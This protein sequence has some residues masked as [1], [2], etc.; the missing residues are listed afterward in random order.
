M[1][2]HIFKQIIG[3]SLLLVMLM[4][5]STY[6]NEIDTTETYQLMYET[7]SLAEAEEIASIFDLDLV[8]FSDFGFSVYEADDIHKKDDYLKMGF[9]INHTHQIVR[10]NTTPDSN[11]D[12]YLDN[13]YAIPMMGVD[14]AWSLELGDPNYLIAIIDTGID[15]DHEEF[16]NRIS[17]L[18]YNAITEEVGIDAVEDENGHGTN[19]AGIIGAT[20]NNQIGIAGIVQNSMLLI[21]KAN[22]TDDPSTTDEDESEVF[23]DSNI[24]K[25]INYAVENG[26]DV[27]NLSLGG[28]GFNSIVQNAINNA[29]DSGSIVVASSGN[30]GT[31]EL[32]Y[33][34]SYNHVISVGAVD[35]NM[36]IASY[37][38]YNDEVDISAPGTAIATTNMNDTYVTASGTSFAAPQVTAIIALFQ[39]YL[40]HYTDAQTIERLY[41]TAMDRG[42]VGKDDFYGHGIINAYQSMLV[43]A[44][45]VSFDTDGGTIIDPIRI[46]KDETF[47]VDDPTKVGYD[48]VGW[49]LDENLTQAFNIGTDTRNL[50]TTLYAKYA[51]KQFIISFVTS[52]TEVSPI[53]VY[54]GNP[55]IEPETSKEGFTFDGWYYDSG[56]TSKYDGQLITGQTTFYAKFIKDPYI[57]NFYVEGI[58]NET[59]EINEGET[60]ELYTP[61]GDGNFLGWYLEP[62]LD[63]L[64]VSSGVTT[65]LNLYAK[66]DNDQYAVVYYESDLETIKEIQYISHGQS[67][68]EPEAPMKTSTASFEYIFLNWS[69]D[70]V[71]ITESL[72]IY[73]IFERQFIEGSV[74]LNAGLD[75]VYQKDVW[76]NAGLN[77]D[78]DLLTYVLRNEPDLEMVGR[79]VL[80]YDLYANDEVV[81]TLVRVVNVIAQPN[82]KISLN[83]DITTIF[84][85]DTYEDAGATSTFGEV[86][87]TNDVDTTTSGVYTVTYQVFY[88][89]QYYTKIKYVYV[90]EPLDIS[91]TQS[92]DI[93]EKQK[94]WLS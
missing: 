20:K 51:L 10:N 94:G 49:Y 23:N 64:Y 75:T 73:P 3:I 12:P 38:N 7:H 69:E 54:Y 33:P 21:I 81:W 34:A 26:A 11:E 24:A 59:Y 46:P 57:I 58:I 77:I 15:T 13:Q 56:Y 53:S 72:D 63:T 36:D 89:D 92:L 61:T 68:I 47:N 8:E 44:I 41:E 19:V 50:D 4:I 43:D 91:T 16:T 5:G 17:A 39:A 80:Y 90:L 30:E 85:G 82:V 35:S 29:F 52:G 71:N 22:N 70:A 9:D 62:S 86:I 60:F 37:S 6:Q 25:G 42:V 65:N 74:T 66:F 48:F 32:L 27:I 93:I 83:P 18:S 87:A 55:L 88:N 2:Q 31:D 28:P 76:D 1:M 84:V 79:Y 78:D 14:L 67:A 40:P 45:T